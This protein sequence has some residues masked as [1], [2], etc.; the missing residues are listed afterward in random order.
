[1][2]NKKKSDRFRVILHET[3][4]DGSGTKILEDKET[5]ITYL[6]HYTETGA[7]MTVLLDEEGDPAVAPER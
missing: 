6:Y 2:K 1:M 7:G 5:G 3:A 4:E